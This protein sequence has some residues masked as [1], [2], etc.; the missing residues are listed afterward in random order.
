MVSKYKILINDE[1]DTILI[2]LEDKEFEKVI[3]KVGNIGFNSNKELEFDMELPKGME[4]YYE[5]ESFCNKIKEVVGDIV[6]KSVN[7]EWS[8]AEKA[9]LLDLESKVRQAF[10]P[11]NLEPEENS[12]FIEMFGKKGYVISE[13]D[14]D[15]LTAIKIKNNKTY[16]FDMP[17]QL[18]FL[19]KEL[20]GTGL[21]LLGE[22]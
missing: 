19:K 14:D 11:Y 13:D 3:A 15:R 4:S 22:K 21:I 10:K 18:A 1:K 6:L 12:S 7:Y 16:Y 8:A 20:T 17:E 9:V 2:Q 5:S